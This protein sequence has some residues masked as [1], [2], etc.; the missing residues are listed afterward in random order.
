MTKEEFISNWLYNLDDK[1]DAV[2]MM[3][4]LNAVIDAVEENIFL[5]ITVKKGNYIDL[6]SSIN[7]VEVIGHLEMIKTAIKNK[8]IN[9]SQQPS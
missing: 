4:D 5:K 9:E 7:S 6:Q 1:E 2:K 3:A 8:V